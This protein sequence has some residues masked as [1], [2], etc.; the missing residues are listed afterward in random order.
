MPSGD[1]IST[2]PECGKTFYLFN[3]HQCQPNSVKLKRMYGK[4][5]DSSEEQFNPLTLM[6]EPPT[7]LSNP[8]TAEVGVIVGRFQSSYIHKGYKELIEFVS[9]IH[10]R[11]IIFLGCNATKVSDHDPIPFWSRRAMLEEEFPDIEVYQIDDVGDVDK[12]SKILDAKIDS[13]LS[14]GNKAILYGSR[15]KCKYTGKWV[16]T[17]VACSTEIS[18]TEIRKHIGLKPQNSVKWREG[19]IY[20]SQNRY[21]VVYPTVDIAVINLAKGDILLGRKPGAKAW[22]FPGGFAEMSSASYELDAIRELKEETG[23]TAVNLEYIGSSLIDDPR[24]RQSKDRIK[25]LFYAVTTWKGDPI[26]GDDLEEVGWYDLNKLT[27]ELVPNHHILLKM[28]DSWRNKL[29]Q[30]LKAMPT[31]KNP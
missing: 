20:A 28:L 27:V 13:L 8:S 24:Y 18:S 21:P 9:N 30:A 6:S 31:P 14:P 29:I 22:R 16:V 26:A 2:C 12:W 7:K 10:H 17:N 11:V 23:L 4:L 5:F 25:T 19:V 3:G 1:M 15:D